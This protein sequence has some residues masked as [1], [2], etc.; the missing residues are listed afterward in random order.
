MRL[1]H[2]E[3]GVELGRGDGGALVYVDGGEDG[4]EE[5]QLGKGEGGKCSQQEGVRC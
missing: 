4:P 2:S 5:V 3:V 1:V